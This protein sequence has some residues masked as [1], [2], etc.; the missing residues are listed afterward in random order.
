[1]KESINILFY[2][3]EEQQIGSIS[4]LIGYIDCYSFVELA[5]KDE[6]H[7]NPRLS[8]EGDITKAIIDS[9]KLDIKEHQNLFS[10]KSKGICIGF[11]R[12]PQISIRV[13]RW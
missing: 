4:K 9:L 3:A 7:A 5:A 13:R 2:Q 10:F 11:I 8:K 6:L 12:S 1:M